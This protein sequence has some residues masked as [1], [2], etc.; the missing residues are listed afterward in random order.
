MKKNVQALNLDLDNELKVVIRSEE[1]G[2][3]E[4]LRYFELE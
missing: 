4:R 2:K 1:I 3:F